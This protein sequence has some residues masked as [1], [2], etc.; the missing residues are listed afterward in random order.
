MHV[1][2]RSLPLGLVTILLFVTFA[3]FDAKSLGTNMVVMLTAALD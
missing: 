2:V 1:K 3:T